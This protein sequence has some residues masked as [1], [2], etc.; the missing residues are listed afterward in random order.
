MLEKSG[1]TP[2]YIV[3]GH[4]LGGTY[5]QIFTDLYPDEVKGIVFID[6]TH[7]DHNKNLEKT[8]YSV[9]KSQ[10]NLYKLGAILADLGVLGA[11]NT[12]VDILGI[13]ASKEMPEDSKERFRNR[14]LYSGKILNNLIKEIQFTDTI[15]S[16]SS[17][18]KR[19]DSLPIL[20]FTA[21][22]KY[23]ESKLKQFE[24]RGIHLDEHQRL[25][26]EMQKELT[27][28]SSNSKQ[29]N[30][31]ANHSSILSKKVNADI[32][33]SEILFMAESIK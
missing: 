7:P 33:N 29:I 10:I 32:I 23:S 15:L 9:T 27:L 31:N 3:A 24:K 18:Y 28:L 30:I 4:S 1:E 19:L 8:G 13:S 22:E 11:L 17:K 21:T 12:V 14:F 2:P 16:R 26:L 6:S 20:I 5:A 25:W